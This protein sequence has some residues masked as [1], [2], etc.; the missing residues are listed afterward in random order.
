M[1]TA[2]FWAAVIGLALWTVLDLKTPGDLLVLLLVV[3]GGAW[4]WK[5]AERDRHPRPITMPLRTI[6]V[7][8]PGSP[9]NERQDSAA[10][11]HKDVAWTRGTPVESLPTYMYHRF[12]D[13]ELDDDARDL[14]AVETAKPIQRFGFQPQPH[15]LKGREHRHFLR[16]DEYYDLVHSAL[17]TGEAIL[18][19][20][21]RLEDELAWWA[22]T[23][24]LN[25]HSGALELSPS[26]IFDRMT[27]ERAARLEALPGWEWEGD[28]VAWRLMSDF[29]VTAG[30]VSPTTREVEF[31]D[32]TFF[33]YLDETFPYLSEGERERWAIYS[34]EVTEWIVSQTV[35]YEENR[36]SPEQRQT[37]ER[38]PGWGEYDQI[39]DKVLSH[40]ANGG[41][42]EDLF[43]LEWGL[44]PGPERDLMLWLWTR[45]Q[46]HEGGIVD[47]ELA[48]ALEAHPGWSWVSPQ[49]L[50]RQRVLE[51]QR[52]QLAYLQQYFERTGPL[53]LPQYLERPGLK[54][55]DVHSLIDALAD[56]EV[57][58]RD[59]EL[60]SDVEAE[61][62]QIPGW[63]W[64]D[65]SYLPQWGGRAR[66][67]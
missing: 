26:Y 10:R 38:I 11:W 43:E 18:G 51:R 30:N 19:P 33:E 62:L 3:A 66:Y 35:A 59:G 40:L 42:R 36:L 65:R 22:V 46:E 13:E 53:D 14:I 63:T 39:T 34:L 8:P 24:R 32:L 17:H 45:F 20:T 48:A 41:T 27:P 64:V 9:A 47:P 55:I 6:L 44:P 25:Q 12:S 31:D 23:M 37:L 54:W 67:Q 50:L 29:A 56:F 57:W 7:P 61:L 15:L 5:Q 60:D 21:T 4:V 1:F 58:R 2:L 52:G 49:L 28:D 16:F